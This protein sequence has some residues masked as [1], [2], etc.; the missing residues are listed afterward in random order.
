MLKIGD[1]LDNKYEILRQISESGNGCSSNVYL[2][3]NP[4]LNQQ[5]IIKE[6]ESKGNSKNLDMVMDEAYLMK[7]FDHP[8]IPRIIDIL[9]YP[10]V[11]YIIMDYIS[12][13]DLAE[14]LSK[15]GPEPQPVV[16]KW[17]RQ[18]VDVMEYLHTREKP[19]IYHDLKLKCPPKVRQNWA[20]KFVQAAE[21]ACCL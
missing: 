3:M 5:W 8:A 6:I 7:E 13:Q 12:G 21:R 17:A 20:V 4:N 11:N 14:Q 1:I 16:L 15:D 2:A 19:V 18:L 9:K 10:D